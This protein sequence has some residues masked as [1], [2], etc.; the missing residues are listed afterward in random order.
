MRARCSREQKN[1]EGIWHVR[2]SAEAGWVVGGG[3]AH[4]G[5]SGIFRP[6]RLFPLAVGIP[7]N[8]NFKSSSHVGVIICIHLVVVGGIICI[9]LVVVG[10]IIGIH[11]VVLSSTT[12]PRTSPTSS[13]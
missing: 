9:H 7:G 3:D 12:I 1:G 6:R 5:I 10:G 8:I 4:R 11:L 2:W 13:S